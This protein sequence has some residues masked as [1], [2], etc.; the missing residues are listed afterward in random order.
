MLE[1]LEIGAIILGLM[2]AG[3]SLIGGIVWLAIKWPLAMMAV[4]FTGAAIF[5]GLFYSELWRS[6]R[7]RRKAELAA[8]S[9]CIDDR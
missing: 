1:L 4:S 8:T 9:R 5:V 2:A 6:Q 7:S 3:C